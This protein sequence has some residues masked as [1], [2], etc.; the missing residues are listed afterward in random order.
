M[1]SNALSDLIMISEAISLIGLIVTAGMIVY[2][3]IEEFVERYYDGD[4]NG[5]TDVDL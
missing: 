2:S 5:S 3:Y 4:Y 1:V